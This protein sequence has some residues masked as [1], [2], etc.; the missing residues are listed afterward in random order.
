MSAINTRSLRWLGVLVPLLFWI[1]VL[2]IEAFGLQVPFSLPAA[3]MEVVLIAGSMLFANWVASSLERQ[4]AEVRRRSE[5][6]EALREA[7]L[8]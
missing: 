3:I 5:H 2:L 4:Q 7:A 6:L 1:A 8:R